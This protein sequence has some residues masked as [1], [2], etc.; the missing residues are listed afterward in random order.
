M[1]KTKAEATK[2]SNSGGKAKK[3]KWS[4]VKIKDKANN[5]VTLDKATYDKI[6]KETPTYKLIT[7]AI[8]VDRM[9]ISASLARVAIKEL[10]AK[11]LI[12][13]VLCHSSLPIYTRATA[14]VEESVP[15]KA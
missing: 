8:L 15:I 11:G 7:T 13:K 10:E 12:K 3:K 4:K 5:A 1:G 2:P 14:A 9:K 6:Y